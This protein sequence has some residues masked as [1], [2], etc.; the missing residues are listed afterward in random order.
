VVAVQGMGI[1]GKYAFIA[2][3]ISRL[4]C[5]RSAPV[6]DLYIDPKSMRNRAVLE[7]VLLR[8]ARSDLK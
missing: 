5:R 7:T 3:E 6:D 2:T 4:I 8:I 1:D